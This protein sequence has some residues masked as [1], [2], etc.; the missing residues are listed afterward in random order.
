[1]HEYIQRRRD[2]ILDRA[3]TRVTTDFPF[4]PIDR[5]RPHLEVILARLVDALARGVRSPEGGKASVADAG[6]R[7]GSEQAAASLPVS[8]LPREIGALSDALGSVSEA[9]GVHFDPQEYHT[10]N[11]IFDG[12]MQSAIEGFQKATPPESSQPVDALGPYFAHE[13]RNAMGSAKLA[14]HAIQSGELGINSGT[15][16]VLLRSFDRVESLAER[17]LFASRVSSGALQRAPI[18]VEDLV[19]N[20]VFGL[21]APIAQRV[22]VNVDPT[23]VFDVDHTAMTSVLDNLLRNAAKYSPERSPI[24]VRAYPDDEDVVIEVADQCGGIPEG[25]V[26]K[27]FVPFERGAVGRGTGLGLPIVRAAVEAHGG[28]ITV[29]NRPGIG[30]VFAVRI[31]V[32]P[33]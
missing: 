25:L 16:R 29:Q 15:G 3:T 17:A 12:A 14:L 8:L 33:R 28:R 23:L 21:G 20:A 30:C 22:A 1:M 19:W 24:D 4:I 27:L 13:L 32:H 11:V 6:A 26:E 18:P 9:D 7:M 5:L 2:G 10:V 31:P